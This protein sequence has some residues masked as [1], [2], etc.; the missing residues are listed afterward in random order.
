ME[1]NSYTNNYYLCRTLNGKINFQFDYFNM[2]VC[3]AIGWDGD[4]HDNSC[5]HMTVQLK[6][7]TASYT[8]MQLPQKLLYASA[9][10]W[11]LRQTAEDCAWY[12]CYFISLRVRPET[13]SDVWW[14][15]T[16]HKPCSTI[17]TIRHKVLIL[18]FF[19]YEKI[20]P[21]YYEH[22]KVYVISLVN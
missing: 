6:N 1:T 22:L 2:N 21:S 9:K 20:F 3:E 13:G 8:A 16:V 14:S 4:K 18:L 19:W 7:T 15:Y 12:T 17:P 5:L 10:L 11:E